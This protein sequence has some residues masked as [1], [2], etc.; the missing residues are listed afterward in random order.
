[1]RGT[2]AWDDSE[3]RSDAP[4]LHNGVEDT[5]RLLGGGKGRRK[6]KVG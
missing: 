2:G 6:E 5:G 1:M 3:G 4:G